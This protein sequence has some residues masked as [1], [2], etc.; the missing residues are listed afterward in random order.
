MTFREK[1]FQEKPDCVGAD[2]VG[3]CDGCPAMYGYET[4]DESKEQ[5]YG[6]AVAD[7]KKCRA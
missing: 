3:G 6:E 4:W 5:C 7:E 1:L 2:Y